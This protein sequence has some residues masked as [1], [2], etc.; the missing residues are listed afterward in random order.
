MTSDEIREV[1]RLVSENVCRDH[2]VSVEVL[3]QE[4]ALKTGAVAPF[5]E[6]YGAMVRVVRVGD[7]SVEFCGGSHLKASGEI[8]AFAIVSESS[9]ASGTRRIEAVAGP[10]ATE[11][12]GRQRALVQEVTSK[13]SAKP[14]EVVERIAAMQKEIKELKKGAQ[15]AR[16]QTATGDVDR[17]AAEAREIEARAEIDNRG[18]LPI[19][20][21]EFPVIGRRLAALGLPTVFV[22]E[23]GYAVAEVGVNTVNVLSGFEEA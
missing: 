22:M 3:P 6:K 23:G 18:K 14:E 15:R 10:A 5:G 21:V 19:D 9:I 2:P 1:E 12:F 20:E 4:E 8:G 11:Y 16:Q 17:V 13:L 7:W